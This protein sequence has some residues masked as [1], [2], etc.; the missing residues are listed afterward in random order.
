MKAKRVRIIKD[1][2]N[3]KVG[4]LLPLRRDVAQSLIDRG[5]AVWETVELTEEFSK[6]I[7]AEPIIT[8]KEIEEKI[9][10]FTPKKNDNSKTVNRGGKSTPSKGSPRADSKRASGKSVQSKT[11][12]KR[13]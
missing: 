1:F 10:I 2:H 11:G 12:A 6:P 7:L 3:K 5:L 13:K 9:E 8:E 4:Q